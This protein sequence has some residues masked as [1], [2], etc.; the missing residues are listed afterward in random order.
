MVK[1]FF[2]KKF[3]EIDEKN[4]YS[5]KKG[6]ESL[7]EP[8]YRKTVAFDQYLIN[9]D[10][11]K[12]VPEI[13]AD[14]GNEKTV[15][16][17]SKNFFE[18]ESSTALRK[19]PVGFYRNL[20]Q[21]GLLTGETLLEI[22]RKKKLL[23]KTNGYGENPNR[24]MAG[25]PTNRMLADATTGERRTI[26]QQHADQLNMDRY[27]RCNDGRAYEDGGELRYMNYSNQDPRID[28][29]ADNNRDLH[30]QADPKIMT[31]CKS[32][33]LGPGRQ[34]NWQEA[35]DSKL[36]HA[37]FAKRN[38]NG[39][40]KMSQL[41]ANRNPL[42][43]NK[44]QAMFAPYYSSGG[45]I[46]KTCNGR[47]RPQTGGLVRSIDTNNLDSHWNK[48]CRGQ[49]G[50]NAYLCCGSCDVQLCKQADVDPH[51]YAWFKAY[52]E[53]G[54]RNPYFN[55]DDCDGGLAGTFSRLQTRID[56]KPKDCNCVFLRKP[57]S[58]RM[59]T[60]TNQDH[61]LCPRCAIKIG[62]VKLSGLKCSCGHWNVPGYQLLKKCVKVRGAAN[63]KK[64][65]IA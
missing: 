55:E 51:S 46:D 52:N 14:G 11:F 19:T 15:R 64:N 5:A 63:A 59:Y 24:G 56:T 9:H 32:L 44:S 38:S 34:N 31:M 36:A 39:Y 25:L 54:N 58:I 16:I 43:V 37:E 27:G 29:N 4:N 8:V 3:S 40:L 22:Q 62:T 30:S 60:V 26:L 33:Q 13:G 23:E 7:G 42:K 50:V 57:N 45:K 49:L 41:P 48:F 20:S 21:G 10:M 6:E 1:I 35:L 12:K 47:A 65:I 2:C 28:L 53:N 61:V 17:L 18:N